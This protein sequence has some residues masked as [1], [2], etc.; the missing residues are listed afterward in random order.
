MAEKRIET[1]TGEI[2]TPVF[3]YILGFSMIF[4]SLFTID[5]GESIKGLAYL[6]LLFEYGREIC[7]IKFALLSTLMRCGFDVSIFGRSRQ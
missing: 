5:F 6:A 4:Y 2:R 1:L 3:V 7:L